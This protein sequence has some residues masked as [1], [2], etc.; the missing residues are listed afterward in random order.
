MGTKHPGT[1]LKSDTQTF[2]ALLPHYAR[3]QWT[4]FT[5]HNSPKSFW[6]F[7]V[8]VPKR[9]PFLREL[10]VVNSFVACA[11]RNSSN[12]KYGK[13]L[14]NCPPIYWILLSEFCGS[15]RFPARLS[16]CAS[17]YSFLVRYAGRVG[18]FIGR[19]VAVSVV[20][21]CTLA[22][23]CSVKHSS[24]TLLRAICSVHSCWCLHC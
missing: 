10:I 6:R 23:R 13:Y 3:L 18:T 12:F 16:R 21:L 14:L 22:K 7:G 1:D 9:F 2:P 17:A 15:C 11:W 8:I 4:H 24:K 5:L 19:S 20:T